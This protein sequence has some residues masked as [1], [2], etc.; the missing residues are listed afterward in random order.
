MSSSFE[1]NT[2]ITPDL[3]HEDLIINLIRNLRIQTLKG[4]IAV[5]LSKA[6]AFSA[7]QAWKHHKG[8]SITRFSKN[9]ESP[10]KRTLAKKRRFETYLLQIPP[11]PK[12][13]R[14][15]FGLGHADL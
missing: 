2:I 5:M 3:Q 14:Q 15:F 12:S 8:L 4:K 1:R 7:M 10:G 11:T 13:D 6:K 9:N